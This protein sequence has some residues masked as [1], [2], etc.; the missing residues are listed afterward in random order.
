MVNVCMNSHQQ[1][2]EAYSERWKV[3]P[4][5]NK[6]PSTLCLQ[7]K[8]DEKKTQHELKKEKQKARVFLSLKTKGRSPQLPSSAHTKC[9]TFYFIS[10]FRLQNFFLLLFLFNYCEKGEKKCTHK[11]ADFPLPLDCLKL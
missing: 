10:F 5:I 3:H 8:E 11:R 7:Q 6:N 9:H 4:C 2:L 1:K